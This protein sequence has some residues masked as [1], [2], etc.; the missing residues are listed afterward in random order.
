ME[1]YNGWANYETWCVNLWFTDLF[2][3]Y[4]EEHLP[5]DEDSCR[6]AVEEH[7]DS[8]VAPNNGFLDDV[9]GAF[10]EEVD[11]KEISDAAT[12]DSDLEVA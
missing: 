4:E 8:I 9:I 6:A 5:L 1:G 10:M 11:W 12:D 3:S 2:L 7:I